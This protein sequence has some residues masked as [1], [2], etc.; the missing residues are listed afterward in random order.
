[1]NPNS[2]TLLCKRRYEFQARPCFR[3]QR[4]KVKGLPPWQ[5]WSDRARRHGGNMR[6]HMDSVMATGNHR[7]LG[8]IERNSKLSG[9]H[10]QG[11]RSSAICAALPEPRGPA[12]RHCATII[13]NH[14][15]P[16]DS[17]RSFSKILKN[18]STLIQCEEK[19]LQIAGRGKQH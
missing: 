6:Q 3:L 9:R 19:L 11:A 4:L 15:L 17:K 1:M 16:P 12:P 10:D 8:L 2:H 18:Q 5:T 14:H 13:S 7:R